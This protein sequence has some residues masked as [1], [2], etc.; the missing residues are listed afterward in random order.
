MACG[1][2]E[3]ADPFPVNVNETYAGRLE[4]AQDLLRFLGCRGGHG[5]WGGAHGL[6]TGGQLADVLVGV[7]PRR[8][9]ACRGE[10][11][12]AY[13]VDGPA[14]VVLAG[15]AFWMLQGSRPHQRSASTDAP[16]LSIAVLPFVDMSA[17]QDQAYFAEGLSEEILNLLAQSTT[18]RVTART[19]SFSFK[20]RSVDIPTIGISGGPMLRGIHCGKA[21]GSG[22]NT[23]SMS[24]QLRSGQI[25]QEA[26]DRIGRGR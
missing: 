24:E 16:A 13:D 25:T 17:E 15:V 18:L 26:V 19:S 10:P 7:R 21:I 11:A 9:D 3:R 6:G 12:V 14:A 5:T 22:T 8:D 4:P 20:G 2:A 23:I 1:S